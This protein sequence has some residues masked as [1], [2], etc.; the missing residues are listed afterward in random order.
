MTSRLEGGVALAAI[1]ALAATGCIDN[2]AE[3]LYEWNQDRVVCSA[4][5]DDEHAPGDLG[6]V[7]DTFRLAADRGA[8]ATLH[9]HIPGTTISTAWLET[10]LQ[11]ADANQLTYLTYKDLATAS[12]GA[13]VALAFDDEAIDAWYD[14]RDQLADHDARVTF[15]VTRWQAS[16]NA[17]G[18]D[19]VH[20][21]AAL[22]HAVE[23]HSVNHLHA[24]AY[25]AEHGIDAYIA[26]EVLPSIEAL[27]QAG[28]TPTTY[29]FPFGETTPE[30]TEAVLQ[31]IDRV[32]VGPADCPK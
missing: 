26:D 22:G 17:A 2:N 13:G 4:P 24:Q 11:E 19:K 12:P 6:F 5:F 23:P 14:T 28:Y 27:R 25:V 20:A 8:V 1:T 3:Y 31:Y 32:R 7:A 9:A 16:W 15:F 21:L 18:R 10:V 29:A 30:I